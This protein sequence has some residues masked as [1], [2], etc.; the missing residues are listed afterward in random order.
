MSL[1]QAVQRPEIFPGSSRLIYDEIDYGLLLLAGPPG[2]GKTIFVK[3]SVFDSLRNG[4][5][6]VYLTTEESPGMIVESMGKFG[7]DISDHLRNDKLRIIDAFSYRSDKPSESKY[8]IKDP[9]SLTNVSIEIEKAREGISNLRFAMDSITSL[10]LNT[11]PG[12]GQ[13]FMQT[14]TGR[15]KAAKALGI[16]V[17]DVGIL[18]ETFLNFL[19]FI[20]DGVI[21]MGVTEDEGRLKRRIRVYS[22]RMGRHDTSWHELRITNRGIEIP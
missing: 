14:V 10:T 22:L 16:C 13:K 8:Y 11:G 4:N 7:W 19:R 17:L 3:Q 5:S 15:L 1:Q 9:E 18:D 6:V 21:E 20:F 2:V 12:L